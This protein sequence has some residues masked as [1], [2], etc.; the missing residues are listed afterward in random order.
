MLE[1]KTD[2]TAMVAYRNCPRL[3]LLSRYAGGTGLDTPV[4]GLALLVGIAVHDALAGIWENK[5]IEELIAIGKASLEKDVDEDRRA[6]QVALFEGIVRAWY[7]VRYPKLLAEFE[8][9]AIEHELTWNMGQ[10]DDV[11]VWDYIRCDG[12]LRRRADGSLFYWEIKTSGDPG[13]N[14]IKSWEHNSQ[15]L[16]NTTAI[17]ELLGERV[18]GVLIEG[19]AKGRL[20]PDKLKTSPWYGKVIQQSPFCYVYVD[21][22][23]KEISLSWQRNYRKMETWKLL[24]IK[25]LV[26]EVMSEADC[27]ALFVPVPPIRPSQLALARHR[28]QCLWQESG[29]AKA[30]VICK[31]DLSQ[32]DRYFPM[33]E[34]HCFRYWGYPCS[35]MGMCFDEEVAKDPLGSGRYVAR[36]PHHNNAD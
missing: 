31:N 8:P 23:T 32:I 3:R 9:V 16:I 21:P 1:I 29:I 34:D 27:N 14:W 36:V 22:V 5:N 19:I 12:L 17:E 25:R 24:P 33:N 11:T 7:R 35:F 4:K 30:L 2:R 15:I 10:K 20:A 28:E 6:E 13:E 18:H 26:N